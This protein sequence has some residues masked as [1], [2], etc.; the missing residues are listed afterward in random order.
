MQLVSV[1]GEQVLALNLAM[2][3]LC[4]VEARKVRPIERAGFTVCAIASVPRPAVLTTGFRVNFA[5]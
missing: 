1:D 2:D 3:E 5:V 4:L